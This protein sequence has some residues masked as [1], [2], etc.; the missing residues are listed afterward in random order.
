MGLRLRG[1]GPRRSGSGQ[2]NATATFLPAAPRVNGRTGGACEQLFPPQPL[3]PLPD[4]AEE[5]G[6]RLQEIVKGAAVV[7]ETIRSVVRGEMPCLPVV[8]ARLSAR[9][10]A[11]GPRS[12]TG[13]LR[14]RGCSAQLTDRETEILGCLDNGLSNKQIAVRLQLALPTVK[15]HLRSLLDK[16][17]ASSP[18]G[19]CGNGPP[20]P[21]D[22]SLARPGPT[23]RS[24]AQWRS[25]RTIRRCCRTGLS[26]QE[27]KDLDVSRT[28]RGPLVLTA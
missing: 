22:V 2:D 4:E 6:G 11:F 8:A 14:S 25:A 5:I 1:L 28:S 27:S 21:L 13:P 9:L 17:E 23:Q 24:V 26:F 12:Q 19:G 18:G 15:N 7:D 3:G 16:L 20:P 10:R